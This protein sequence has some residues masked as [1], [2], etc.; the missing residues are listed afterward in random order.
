MQTAQDH[1]NSLIQLQCGVTNNDWGKIGTRSLVARLSA[2]GNKEHKIDQD[3][4]YAELWMGTHTLLSSQDVRTGISLRETVELP[5]ML[6][7]LSIGKAI[8]IQAHPDKQLA[9]QLHKCDPVTYPD[10]NHKPEMAVAIT[11]FEALCGFRP[12]QEIA[13]FLIHIAPLRRIVGMTADE[14]IILASQDQRD[15]AKEESALRRTWEALLHSPREQIIACTRE[16]M[17]LI[18][19]GDHDDRCIAPGLQ[20]STALIARLHQQYPEDVGLFAV[21]FMNYVSLTPGEAV[22]VPPGEPHAYLSGD[23]V[24]CMASS[25]NTVRGGFTNKTKDL[26]T[27]IPMLSYSY[28]APL[29]PRVF[30]V[31]PYVRSA[32]GAVS[33]VLYQSAAEEFDVTKTD[34]FSPDAEVQFYPMDG[35]S[36]V[37][38]IHGCGEIRAGHRMEKVALGSA[39]YIGAGAGISIQNGGTGDLTVFQ[40]LIILKAKGNP[41]STEDKKRV[42]MI[43][44][45][46]GAGFIGSN[47]VKALNERGRKDIIVVDDMTD[48]SKFI[49]IADCEIADYLDV[50]EFR[51]A[52]ANDS[53]TPPPSVIFHNGA[54]SST[55]ETNGKYMLDVNFTFSKELFHYCQRHDTRLIYA[56]SAAVYGSNSTSGPLPENSTRATSPLNV[57]AY[58]KMLFDQYIEGRR[59]N[60]TSQ[61]VGLRY[62][63]VYGPREQHKGPMAS[64]VY[65]MHQQLRQDG[66]V[67]LFGEYDGYKAGMQERDFVYVGDVVKVN[68]FFLENPSFSGIFDLGKG[69]ADTFVDA[70][71]AVLEVTGVKGRIE[72][73]PFPE[74]L[75][76]RYQSSTCSDVSGLRRIGF[77]GSEDTIAL[78][79]QAP[80]VG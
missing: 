34:L 54:C 57:Y 4:P 60:A 23:V 18:P 46:G 35:P 11:P 48:G 68:M 40:A 64:I 20:V 80:M 45:T 38:C 41:S 19:R 50:N 22:F 51:Q 61:V 66:V 25:A 76:G 55:T 56:S 43:V 26:H 75:K 24:E 29:K 2:A 58:S 30:P 33:S 74:H 12:L 32:K 53:L 15:P 37:I 14:C 44:V 59:G 65:Q 71:N 10:A 69:R 27:F 6:K 49:N 8:C 79:M 16:L 52:I 17:S 70:A 62:F 31:N 72:Y 9:Q 36:L 42:N 78:E 5:F 67:K 21:F 39:L 1:A 7:V 47:I 13:L 63:N 73:I 3:I 28:R 77:R